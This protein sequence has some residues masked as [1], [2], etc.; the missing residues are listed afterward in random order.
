MAMDGDD[1]G[2]GVV[3]TDAAVTVSAAAA[4]AAAPITVE[5]LMI[6]SLIGVVGDCLPVGDSFVNCIEP[7]LVDCVS[8]SRLVID[9]WQ[10]NNHAE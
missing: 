2:V 10:C 1:C 3:A 6:V 8:P 5:Q 9:L 4:E 7:G